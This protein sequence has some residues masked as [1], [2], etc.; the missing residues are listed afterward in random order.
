MAA[1]SGHLRS[2]LPHG[3]QYPHDQLGGEE[4]TVTIIYGSYKGAI[5]TGTRQ[6]WGS[7]SIRNQ[8]RRGKVDG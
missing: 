5:V 6:S 8:R 2:L 7:F 1:R 3:L 4:V